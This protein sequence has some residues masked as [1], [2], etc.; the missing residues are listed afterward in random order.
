MLM[1]AAGATVAAAGTV[2]ADT[3]AVAF[4]AAA[5]AFMAVAAAFTAE[6]SAGCTAVTPAECA[7]CRAVPLA[8]AVSAATGAAP[9]P[10]H[11]PAECTVDE[12][13]AWLEWGALAAS[14]PALAASLR[15]LGAFR[16][17]DFEDHRKGASPRDI[18]R[19]APVAASL[20]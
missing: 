2:V 8:A 19:A 14:H 5:V 11:G 3:V 1:A 12:L 16:V 15:A 17:R 6:V 20:V 7:G 9:W 18:S 10:C 4:T 13:A